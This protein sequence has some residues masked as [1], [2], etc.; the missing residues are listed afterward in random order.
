[1][2]R[3]RCVGFAF[4]ALIAATGT[5][6]AASL[7]VTI[8]GIDKDGGNVAV[9]LYGPEN[10]LSHKPLQAVNVQA[11][12]GSQTVTF[13]ELP[14]GAYGILAFHDVN[15][16]R[17]LDMNFLGIPT[18][19]FGFSNNPGHSHTPKFDEAKFMVGDKPVSLSIQLNE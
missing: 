16:N 10:W 18:E 7:T 2:N 3:M 15:T 8:S 17:D 4:L 14:P 19:Q 1:M 12:E 11:Q 13:D 5:A 6:S 9:A